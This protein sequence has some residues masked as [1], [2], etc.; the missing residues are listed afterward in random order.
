MFQ[1]SRISTDSQLTYSIEFCLI[2]LFCFSYM[3]FFSLT[4]ADLKICFRFSAILI[5]CFVTCASFPFSLYL[6]SAD[7]HYGCVGGAMISVSEFY[8]CCPNNNHWILIT[9]FVSISIAVYLMSITSQKTPSPQKKQVL[10]CLFQDVIY[11]SI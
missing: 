10:R 9:K 7:Q 8:L 3:P 1:S 5:S 6:C 4:F 11:K 2:L